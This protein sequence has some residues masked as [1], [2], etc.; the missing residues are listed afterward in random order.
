[1]YKSERE[2]IVQLKSYPTE[3]K[4]KGTREKHFFE[5]KE[6]FLHISWKFLT[7]KNGIG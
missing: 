6:R 5:W 4:Q 2:V 3:S 7:S 1:M